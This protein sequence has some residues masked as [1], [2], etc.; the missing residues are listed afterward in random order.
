M[1]VEF[2]KTAKDYAKY[3]VGLPDELYDRLQRWDIG[4]PGQRVLDLATGTGAFGRGFAVRGCQVTGVDMGAHLM[5]EA[6]Q[7]DAEA[8]VSLEYVLAPA[9]DTGLHDA[10]YDVVGA[11]T[12]WHWF[13]GYAAAR[14]AYRVLKPGGKLV[15]AYFSWIPLPGNV[16]EATEQLILSHN[17]GWPLS[18]MAGFWTS[19]LK[20]VAGAGLSDI[21]T[22]SFDILVPYTHEAW[23][24]RIRASAGVGASLSPEAVERFDEE[25]GQVLMR[26]FPED[27]LQVL[28]R[29]FAVIGHQK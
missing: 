29:A 13:D 27:P 22:F 25:H 20:D 4:L 8:D 24:G 9:E 14:E 18:G 7:L 11:A 28:H 19:C 5:E 23:R 2:D 26:D 17:P 10:S 15:I 21:E 3:C 1:N 6:K 16:V 12:A